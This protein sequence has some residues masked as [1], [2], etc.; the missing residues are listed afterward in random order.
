MLVTT[1]SGWVRVGLPPLHTFKHLYRY[2]TTLHSPLRDGQVLTMT[3]V[4][5]LFPT[6]SIPF[7]FTLERYFL[8]LLLLRQGNNQYLGSTKPPDGAAR[9]SNSGNS[10]IQRHDSSARAS[11]TRSALSRRMID[12]ADGGQRKVP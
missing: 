10:G 8:G 5:F 6:T 12:A 11:L 7:R 4:P 1:A 9:Q 2:R 3:R